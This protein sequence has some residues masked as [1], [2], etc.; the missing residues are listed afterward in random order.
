MRPLFLAAI[1]CAFC[2]SSALHTDAAA[3]Q[4]PNKHLVRLY[5]PT[6]LKNPDTQFLFY[7][8]DLNNSGQ[9]VGTTDI[10]DNFLSSHAASWRNGRVTFQRE[11]PGATSSD[12]IALN[13]HGDFVA[14]D[15]V[16]GLGGANASVHAVLGYNGKLTDLGMPKGNTDFDPVGLNNRRQVIGIGSDYT[17]YLWSQGRFSPLAVAP[18]GRNPF[19]TAINN[20]GSVAGWEVVPADSMTTQAALWRDGSVELLGVLPGTTDSE[21]EALNDFDHVVGVSYGAVEK[22]FLWRDGTMT[23]LPSVV[24]GES[25]EALGINDWD[26]VTGFEISATDFQQFPVIWENGRAT[27]L[28]D[29]IRPADK[30]RM[31]PAIALRS[32]YSINEWGQILVYASPVNPDWYGDYF[33]LLTPVYEWQ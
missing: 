3:A 20:A 25:A 27:R 8:R 24:A 15:V 19:P 14:V 31:D 11:L 5:K 9:L 1:S 18:G 17:G 10:P 12:G 7:P 29:L 26:Q 22:A 30:A 28:A 21:A 16:N 13:D 6:L 4:S 2:V 23:A 33:Y 32:A